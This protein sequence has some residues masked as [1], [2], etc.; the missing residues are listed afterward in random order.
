[1]AENGK[2]I[3]VGRCVTLD[4]TTQ[5]AK[6]SSYRGWTS[7]SVPSEHKKKNTFSHRPSI[8]ASYTRIATVLEPTNQSSGK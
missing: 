7:V 2:A 4:F 3:S 8:Q 1:M 5:T 6:L